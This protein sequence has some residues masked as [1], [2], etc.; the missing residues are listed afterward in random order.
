M[1]ELNVGDTDGVATCIWLTFNDTGCGTRALLDTGA[2]IS[3]IPRSI[4]ES[5]TSRPALI[6]PD[7]KIEGA[8][9][10]PIECFGRVQLSVTFGK[11]V[12]LQNFYVC[13]NSVS[14]LLGRD[15]MRN[16]D[17]YARPAHNAVYKQG[18]KIPAFDLAAKVRNRVSLISSIT[19]RP[20]QELQTVAAVEGR[21]V[22]DDI[23][24]I[25]QPAVSLF[26]R[27]GVKVAR[28]L[29]VP[30]HRTCHLRLLN[31][32]DE[33]VRLWSGQ[34]VAVL[35][36]AQET[37]P[38][39]DQDLETDANNMARVRT[40]TAH[41]KEQRHIEL[42]LRTVDKKKRAPNESLPPHVQ[43]LYDRSLDE[44]NARQQQELRRLLTTYQDV[45]AKDA[46]DI[47]CT[48]WVKHDV[49]TGEE[50]PVRQ[51]P[52]RVRFEQRPV[53]QN[54][55]ADLHAQGRIRPSHS[56]WGSNVVLVRK[57]QTDATAAPEWRMCIDYREL[58]LKTKNPHTY[59]LPRIDDT[60]DALDRARFF[61]TLDIQQGY[62]NV[63][64]TERAKE[65]TAFHVPCVNPSHWEWVHM[66]FGL[67]G[68][69]RTFQRLMDRILR[70]LEHRIAL[71]YL[72]DVIVYGAQIEE[73]LRNLDCVFERLLAAGVKL[74]GRKCHLFKKETNYL[75]HIISHEGVKCDPSK[76][77]AVNEKH[78]PKTLKQLKSFLGMVCYYS[79]F[80]KDFAGVAHPLYDLLK[81]KKK[82]KIDEWQ[83]PQQRAFDTL[84]RALVTAPVLA[85][86]TQEGHYILDTDAS[87][88]ACGAV[89]SQVQK[90]A[91]GE[92]VERVIAYYSKVFN[93]AEQR[94]CARRREMLAI[95]KAMKHFEV[96]LRG[97]RFT[98]R[99]DHASLQYIKTLSTMSD[100]MYRWVLDLE[101]FDYRI[102][103]RAGKDHINADTLS[104]QPCQGKVCICEQVE[105]FERRAKNKVSTLTTFDDAV[106]QQTT[107]ELVH[108]IAVTPRWSNDELRKKQR[109]DIDLAL[110]YRAL[111]AG[112]GRPQWETYSGQSPACKAYFAEWKRLELHNG[113]I[114]RRWENP[115]GTVIRL[116]ILIPRALQRDICRQVHDG[117]TTAHMGKR[118]TLRLLIR[119]VHWFRMDYDIGW[120]IKSCITCQ[121]RARPHTN[122]KAP[123]RPYVSGN[124]NEC[125][126]MDIVGP[127][128]D[129]VRGFKYVLSITDHFTKY[130]RAVP[131]RD[132]KAHTVASAF[133]ERWIHDFQQPMQL[134]TDKGPNFESELMHQLCDLYGI[135]KTRTTSYHPQGN[136]QNERYNQSIVDIVAKLVDRETYDDWDLQLPTGVAAYNATEHAATGFTP[137]RLVFGRELPHELARM[138][139][140]APDDTTYENWDLYVQKLEENQRIAYDAARQ[141]LGKA[142][143]VYKKQYGRK[144]K[145]NRYKTGDAVKL[146]AHLQ[147]ERGTK[148]FADKFLVPYFVIDALSDIH[149][150]VAR[151]RD[152]DVRIV[153]HDNM[154]KTTVRDPVD[155]KWVYDLAES[156]E[157]KPKRTAATNV[158][159]Q[160]GDLLRRLKRVENRLEDSTT[161]TGRRRRP[162]R[163]PHVPDAARAQDL[164]V[165]PEAP[166]AATNNADTND[167]PTQ[168]SLD[169]HTSELTAQAAPDH[170]A[171]DEPLIDS[172]GT[173]APPNSKKTSRF[174]SRTDFTPLPKTKQVRTDTKGTSRTKTTRAR[175]ATAKQRREQRMGASKLQRSKDVRPRHVQRKPVTNKNT[176]TE[177]DTTSEEEI[178]VTPA[179]STSGPRRSARL[180][181]PR[182]E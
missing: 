84:K 86:P 27:T 78:A 100:Q 73:V 33:P 94:Y 44:L 51:C 81:G 160:M 135:E 167:Q 21:T 54:T 111:E 148:K 91:S 114:Y 90:T 146:R 106:R 179:P 123:S 69:P 116:Q 12:C 96:Y 109:E 19:L 88:F 152:Q 134:H 75:G 77:E 119:S 144:L 147:P 6:D 156:L 36:R 161:R 55:I 67:V 1:N 155:L 40:L 74:K 128:K 165:E 61:C 9:A 29:T 70:G 87:N 181:K 107:A 140:P 171:P 82:L 175:P 28:L 23:T 59:L 58:N 16:N 68:A 182:L 83:E 76:V 153:H 60:L 93:S 142:A 13:E 8:N 129:S 125:V 3:L 42:D 141:A 164:P 39:R 85:Y 124:F 72:D 46:N 168:G 38:Y 108:A 62:H 56:E 17:V 176:H 158:T 149:Y 178:D 4:Y 99:T 173:E 52:R 65:K 157:R 31:P 95:V 37:R 45:F 53:L 47:G 136:A 166:N 32:A 177:T 41:E 35:Q 180:R 7:K 154:E 79:K 15:F 143:K 163:A 26:A 14:T 105:E 131:L 57:K 139:P 126:A 115:A 130:S 112:Q 127:V 102:A 113:I 150:R 89:L 118:R 133:I 64:L 97:P 174:Q 138:L 80:I 50:L 71:A 132:M 43:E 10:S 104:R 159:A 172:R 49:D 117:R 30:Q 11:F 25:V 169:A 110:V 92:D 20:G 120:W 170:D 151:G 24:C 162:R 145:L 137:N 18:V 121:R 103:I 5:M 66:P 22:A 2:G 98:V 122:A 63:E 101:E 48:R 34:T